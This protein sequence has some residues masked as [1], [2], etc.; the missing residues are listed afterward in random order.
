[1]DPCKNIWYRADQWNISLDDTTSN[2]LFYELILGYLD[3]LQQSEAPTMGDGCVDWYAG[4]AE[5]FEQYLKLNTKGCG[6][7]HDCAD[8]CST[9]EGA[10]S[11][12]ETLS[13]C[14]VLPVVESPV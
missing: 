12:P 10:F 14:I 11:D 1:M 6:P 3:G 8:T 5:G 4:A 9:I 13:N 2:S 7:S